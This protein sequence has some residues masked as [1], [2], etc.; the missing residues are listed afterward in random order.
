MKKQSIV[1]LAIVCVLVSCSQKVSEKEAVSTIKT[2]LKLG[3]NDKLQIVGTSIEADNSAIVKFDLNDKK[4]T[5]KLR[6]YDQGWQL[7]EIQNELGLFLLLEK[8]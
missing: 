2:G 6:K 7:D 8:V 4:W 3:E 1:L 5:A